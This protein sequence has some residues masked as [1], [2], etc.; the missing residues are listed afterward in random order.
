MFRRRVSL[1][2]AF[3]TDMTALARVGALDPV[4]GMDETIDR[5]IHI[6]ARKTKNNPLLIGEP[7]VGKTAAVEGLAQRI[8]KGHV[9]ASFKHKKV[10]ALNLAELMS[11]TRYRGELEGRLRQ[12]LQM[13]ESHSREVILF[14]DELHMIE[15]ARG[16]EGALDLADVLK[17]ALSRGDIQVIGATTWREYE[18][19]LRPDV[20]LDRRFQAVLVEEPSPKDALS[21]L[22][23]ARPA[24]E[25]FHGVRVTDEALASAVQ[26]S[27]AFIH[28][29]FLP[30][31]AFDVIDEAC[32]KV[33]IEAT[34]RPHVAALGLVHEAA[35][36]RAKRDTSSEVPVVTV[37]DVREVAQQWHKHSLRPKTH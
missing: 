6:I 32:A 30:D 3:T 10:L 8:V 37:E 33:A 7:G 25:R 14:I 5:V 11:G 27:V 4:I 35:R 16:S 19:H 23:G 22:T 21:I 36:T 15:Q 17:P 28:D 26:A 13:F 2:S 31:K 12:M 20:A 1:E 9:P 29:R 18:M 24:F 34:Q